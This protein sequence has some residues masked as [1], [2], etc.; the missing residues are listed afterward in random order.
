MMHSLSSLA[1]SVNFLV[2]CLDKATLKIYQVKKKK[3]L[4]VLG[5]IF[6]QVEQQLGLSQNKTHQCWENLV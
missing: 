5:L 4:Q 3:L 6:K 1:F 2:L